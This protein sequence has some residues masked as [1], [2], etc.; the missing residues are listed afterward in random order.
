MPRAGSDSLEPFP[1]VAADAAVFETDIVQI[2]HLDPTARFE[3]GGDGLT[4]VG[5][6]VR[7]T[8]DEQAAEDVIE[9]GGSKA[10]VGGGEFLHV[11]LDVG[12]VLRGRVRALDLRDG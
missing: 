11:A 2:L 8:A 4:H 5:G 12:D 7:H 1:P 9:G 10:G 6:P 3:Q